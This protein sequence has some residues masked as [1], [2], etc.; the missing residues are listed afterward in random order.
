MGRE[1]RDERGPARSLSPVAGVT[2]VDAATGVQEHLEIVFGEGRLRQMYRPVLAFG[3]GQAQESGDAGVDRR[4]ARADAK[5]D[6]PGGCLDAAHGVGALRLVARLAIAGEERRLKRELHVRRVAGD[7]HATVE[8]LRGW[9]CRK[10]GLGH[11]QSPLGLFWRL[12]E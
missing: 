8:R 3:F 6:A 11:V 2:I 12:F 7:K 10:V 4:I 5:V 1:T 9:T